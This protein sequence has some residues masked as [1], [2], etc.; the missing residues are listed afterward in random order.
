[1]QEVLSTDPTKE[2]CARSGMQV[3]LVPL[4]NM[5]SGCRS[6]VKDGG[7]VCMPRSVDDEVA[8]DDL[9]EVDFAS[10]IDVIVL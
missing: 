9:I 10:A 5:I 7:Y 8:M 2:T 6:Y 1:M 4:G 3:L